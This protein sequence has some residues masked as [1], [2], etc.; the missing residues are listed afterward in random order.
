M[1]DRQPGD[2]HAH[3]LFQR[4]CPVCLEDITGPTT[5]AAF[6]SGRTFEE[7]FAQLPHEHSRA[8]NAVVLKF[9]HRC[10]LN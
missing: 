10:H 5:C 4:G 8:H 3:V 9:V 1:A 2:T 6:K 7:I